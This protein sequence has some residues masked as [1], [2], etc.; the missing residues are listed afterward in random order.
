[1]KTSLILICNGSKA[2]FYTTEETFP[3]KI[4]GFI[5]VLTHHES[6][7]KGSDLVA[8]RAGHYQKTANSIKGAYEE[9]IEPVE[10]EKLQFAKQIT[11]YLREKQKEKTFQSLIVIAPSHFWGLLEK[12]FT[13][14][15][16]EKISK[17]I[18]KDYTHYTE[19]ELRNV[20]S[21]PDL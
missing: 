6:R 14:P 20:L 11:G 15:L 2:I 21:T 12:H 19:E 16:S 4:L 17:V 13:K 3:K 8:D 5:N 1:M 10:N 18:Q 9:L 7:L